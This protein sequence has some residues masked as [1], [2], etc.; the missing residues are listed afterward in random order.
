MSFNGQIY[1]ARRE[2][3]V[4]QMGE[5]VAIL[6]A[7]PESIRSNDTGYRYRQDS[8]FYYL[9]GFP[10]PEALCVLSPQH[11]KERFILFV[12]PRD[13]EKETW[14]AVSAFRHDRKSVLRPRAR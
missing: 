1:A 3:F 12:R 13:K 7:A 4:K 8:D 2:A 5:G 14:T 10:E 6:P 11:E 9:T